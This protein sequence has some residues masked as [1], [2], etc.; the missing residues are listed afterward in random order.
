MPILVKSDL[1]KNIIKF[2]EQSHY[3]FSPYAVDWYRQIQVSEKRPKLQ[4]TFRPNQQTYKQSDECTH[5]RTTL[6]F[7]FQL[8]RMLANYKQA[9]KTAAVEDNPE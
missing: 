5:E 7:D 2:S 9:H 3:G 6:T 8:W 4:C 1:I